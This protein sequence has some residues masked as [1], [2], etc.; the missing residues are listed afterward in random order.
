M[1]VRT[2][3][4]SDTTRASSYNPWVG[5]SWMS[6]GCTVGGLRLTAER[7]TLDREAVLRMWTEKV[8][9]LSGDGG[10]PGRIAPGCLADLVMPDR[11]FFVPDVTNDLTMVGGKVVFAKGAFADPARHARLVACPQFRQLWRPG[12]AQ[13]AQ[14]AAVRSGCA[15]SCG[16]HGHDHISSRG[17][18]QPVSDL[19]SFWGA[20][21]WAC[22]AV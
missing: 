7:N 2:S 1:G 5:L 9:W 12:Q 10:R 11:D 22:W 20:L 16:V 8:A 13:V 6:S 21:G 18:H 17:G 19:K 3:A 14:R 4:G 15:S